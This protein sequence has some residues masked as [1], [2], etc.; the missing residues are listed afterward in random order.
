MRQNARVQMKRRVPLR[1]RLFVVVV[2]AIVPLAIMAA[3]AI[4]AG[5][6]QQR[7]QAERSGLDV[8]RAM[9]TAVAAELRRTIS[10]LQVLSSSRAMEPL[11]RTYL[12]E[13]ARLTLT[14]QTNWRAISL[15]DPEGRI[16]LDTRHTETEPLLPSPDPESLQRVFAT[17][18]PVV[19]YL[20]KSNEGGYTLSVRVP[21]MREGNLLFV[22]SAVLDPNAILA[23]LTSHRAAESW[24]VAV[25]DAKGTRV[26]RTRST[27]Q[28]LGTPFSPTLV[29]MM[30]KGGAEGTGTTYASEGDSVFTAYTRV[31]EF[32]WTT[33]VGQSTALVE[34]AARDSFMT[35]G[36]GV[37]LSTL[38]GALAALF[39]AR[40][41][42][43]PIT[44]LREAAIGMGRGERFNAP[45]LDVQEL[46]DVST[47]LRAADEGQAQARAEREELLKREQAAR[48]AAEAANRAKDEFLAM[49][50]HE[51]RNPLGA[52]SNAAYVLENEKLD[53]ET[54]RRTR[55]IIMRQVGHLTRLTD[56]LLDAARALMGKIVLRKRPLDLSAVAMQSIA[57]L[58]GAQ[59]L[60]GHRIIEDFQPAWVEADAVRLDQVIV[61]LVVNAVKYTPQGGT[62]RVSVR[63]EG[64]EAI[65]TVAD[66]GIGI[67]PELAPQVFDLFVQGDR[68]LD[69][70]EG[71]LGIGLT[72]VRKLAELHGGTAV[73]HSDGPGLGSEFI[74]R[75]P[76]TEPAAES[77]DSAPH[78][79][80]GNA[81]HI[82]LVEDNADARDTLAMLLEMQGHRVDTAADGPSG[83]EKALALQ[84]EVA[85]VDVGLPGM[86][87]YE[88]ARRIRASR[89]MRRP[90]LVA[91]RGYGAP[92]ER[93]RALAAG[94]DTHVVKPVDDQTLAEILSSAE[95]R[96]A[97]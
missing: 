90:V 42:V 7:N 87:G 13:R 55:A 18:A 81:R 43:K 30:A 67:A 12:L 89:G 52:I 77:P 33:A 74:V 10:V 96:E 85:L 63:R 44:Q 48:A 50:G 83:L 34:A 53:G 66:D 95:S 75:L 91:L 11:D 72:L 3:V 86:D 41:I 27:E 92:E 29:E 37:A 1:Q 39:M 40:R 22:I 32:G 60:Q 64:R 19:G 23:V 58:K 62:I 25:A 17:H 8:A 31:G 79:A 57:T 80:G 9:H 6:Q 65:L 56:D 24:I 20:V 61:N 70:N 68:A 84:P 82:L 21:V 49:L 88:V 54:A 94:F 36:T 26:A 38:L 93:E 15:A 2:A 5:Y 35:F 16:I 45:D 14:A 51:L 59:R 76:V 69:R 97:S 47:T 71:G 28:T 4:W 46:H 78:V 73:V